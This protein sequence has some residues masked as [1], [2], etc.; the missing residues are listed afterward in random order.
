VKTLWN[1]DQARYREWIETNRALVHQLSDGRIG[2]VHIPDMGPAGFAEFHRGY[3]A[4]YNA[5]GLIIDVRWN[6]GGSVSGLLL[7]KLTRRR[8]AYRFSRLRQP[9]PYP[10]ESPAG[11]MVALTDEHAASDG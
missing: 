5:Q 4:E 2:Y 8:I 6:R 9:A 10:T 1:D 7:E 11:P 3:L